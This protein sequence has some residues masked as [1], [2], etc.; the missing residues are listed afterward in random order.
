M[1]AQQ[2]YGQIGA[3]SDANVRQLLQALFDQV[4]ELQEQ[5]TALQQAALQR[6]GTTITAGGRIQ[7][8]SAPQGDSDAVNLRTLKSY[9]A[10]QIAAFATP[11]P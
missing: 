9:V 3:I 4:R 10:G 2:G 8:V 7:A 11:A 5:V 6:E 1:A